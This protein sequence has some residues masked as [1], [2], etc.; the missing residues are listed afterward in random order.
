MGA[1]G[2]AW[3]TWSGRGNGRRAGQHGSQGVCLEEVFQ[4]CSKFRSLDQSRTPCKGLISS[5]ERKERSGWQNYITMNRAHVFNCH[6]LSSSFRVTLNPV[7]PFP[8]GSHVQADIPSG[9]SRRIL[10]GP[11]WAPEAAQGSCPETKAL[12]S[13]KFSHD[14]WWKDIKGTLTGLFQ[15][16]FPAGKSLPLVRHNM[17][18]VDSLADCW[19]PSEMQINIYIYIYE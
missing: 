13:G 2:Q 9:A 3:E 5:W 6:P 8:L 17:L 7:A 10:W 4:R 19:W 12:E 14:L 11:L 15:D 18:Q 1:F 16:S